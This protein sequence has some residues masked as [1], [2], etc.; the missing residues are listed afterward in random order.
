M[1]RNGAGGGAPK[2]LGLPK[3]ADIFTANGFAVFIFDYRY[4][5]ASDGEPRQILDIAAQR[6]D[7]R[8]A[9]DYVRHCPGID[10]Q[11]IA[12]WGS[13]NS[14]GHVLAVAAGDPAIAAVISQ[15]PMIDGKHRGRTLRQRLNREVI[16]RS[17]GFLIAA[18]RDINRARRGQLPYYVPI[19][20][21]PGQVAIFTEQDARECHEKLGG[22]GVGWR[23]LIA[24]RFFLNLPKYEE[25][26]AQHISMPLLMI[27]ADLDLQASSQFA[28]EI[29]S[30]VP[31]AE[32]LHYPVGHFDVYLSPLF[33][34]IVKEQ[35]RFLQKHL[36]Q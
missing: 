14:G 11:R 29:A 7:Y 15:V 18:M 9:I 21:Q 23:N 6:D 16:T 19:V 20:G 3:Y 25:G 13:S 27:L 17:L 24:P 5:G 32:I 4:F 33:D 30:K 8:S 28:A 36:L 1:R 22:E 35:V 2:R 34:L 26:T 31:S 10:P 12:L